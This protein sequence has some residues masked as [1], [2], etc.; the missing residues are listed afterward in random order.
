MDA[1]PFYYILLG[2]WIPLLWPALALRGWMRGALL[3]VVL[4]G[5][6]ATVNEVWQTL[7]LN[8]IRIDIFL[9]VIVLGALYAAAA[10]N[11]SMRRQC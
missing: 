1:L 4:A 11:S 10:A 3:V 6:L 2:L 9:F 5:V 7:A 8:A